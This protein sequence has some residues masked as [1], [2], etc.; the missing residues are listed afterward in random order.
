MIL[1][2][3]LS[4]ISG[5]F[6]W[7]GVISLLP[8]IGSSVSIIGLWFSESKNLRIA[9]LFAVSLWLIYAGLIHS[10]VSFAYNAFSIG[11]IVVGMIKDYMAYKK[12]YFDVITK[13]LL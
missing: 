9:S 2:F 7:Q 10:W 12:K 1:F 4:I 3:V 5:I 13:G 6:S 11:S 8:M